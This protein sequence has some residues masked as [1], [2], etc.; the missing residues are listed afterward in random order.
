LN[1]L[2]SDF[3]RPTIYLFNVNDWATARQYVDDYSIVPCWYNI[4]TLPAD[5]VRE[6]VRTKR[7]VFVI[8]IDTQPYYVVPVPAWY[9]VFYTVQAPWECGVDYDYVIDPDF[10]KFLGETAGSASDYCIGMGL[11]VSGVKNY[12]APFGGGT[13][14]WGYKRYERGAVMETPWDGFWR[15]PDKL[16]GFIDAISN[17]LLGACKPA[18]ILYLASYTGDPD[19]HPL[20]FPI[21]NCFKKLAEERGWKIIDLRG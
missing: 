12:T 18:R 13:C 8:L 16:K 11:K 15:T 7:V 20:C 17:I 6:L 10:R 2:A 19:V 3:A 1:E 9:P 21:D 14:G 5:E 4:P